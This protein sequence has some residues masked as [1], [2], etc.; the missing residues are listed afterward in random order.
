MAIITRTGAAL[1]AGLLI[2]AGPCA[3]WA[4]A[5]AAAPQSQVSVSTGTIRGAEARDLRALDSAMNDMTRRGYPGLARHV[6]ALTTALDRAP[7]PYGL[8]DRSLPNRLIIRSDDL[9]QT[10]LLAT[11]AGAMGNGQNT[12]VLQQPNVYGTI[13]LLLGSEAV[14]RH[15]YASA[16]IALDK[17]LALQP[18]NGHLTS[19]KASALQGL[20]QHEAVLQMIDEALPKLGF[21]ASVEEAMLYRRR[22]ASL[23]E[24]GR[25]DDAKAAFEKSI[26]V[27][28]DNPVAQNELEYIRQLQAG[29]SQRPLV[30]IAAPIATSAPPVAE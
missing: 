10:L 13:A 28:P 21:G 25:L 18:D 5:P 26:E 27:L 23:I 11:M 8:I 20:G 14:E 15:D 16:I 17:G 1:A 22:G 2:G 7:T 30:L 19:E 29:E 4:S 24:L 3:A 6:A 9:G 12:V